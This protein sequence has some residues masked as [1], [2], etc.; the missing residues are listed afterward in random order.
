[1]NREH[2]NVRAIIVPGGGANFGSL[3]VACARIG[4]ETDVS[5]DAARIRAAS[6]VLLPGVGAATHAMRSLRERGLDRVLPSLT[7]P[8]LGICLGMQLLFESSEESLEIHTPVPL[9]ESNRHIALEASCGSGF[10]RDALKEA[11]DRNDVWGTSRSMAAEAAPTTPCPPSARHG[12]ARRETGCLG[13]L[14][15]HVRRLPA[16][17]SWPH[18]G[19]NTLRN[20]IEHPLLS[21]IG[22][23]DW[24]YFVHGYAAPV[25]GDTLATSEHGETFAAAVADGNVHGVQF[26][27]EKSA[28]AGRRLL[29]NFFALT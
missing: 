7:Q 13:L 19:W 12:S 24:F 22:E 18:M 20:R 28:A 1:M 8:L 5:D 4:V 26:H 16:A 10:S 17:P 2:A 21:G 14:P 25:G 11:L 23:R 27:P 15:G 3:R 9:N 6:H 29:T